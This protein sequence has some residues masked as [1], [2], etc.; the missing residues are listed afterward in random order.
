MAGRITPERALG[1]DQAADARRALAHV[2]QD[3]AVHAPDSRFCAD[4]G[5]CPTETL[6]AHGQ[7]SMFHYTALAVVESCC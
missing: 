7:A 5:S 3:V 1:V 4:A 2:H 6:R